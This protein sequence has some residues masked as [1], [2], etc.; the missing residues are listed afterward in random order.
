MSSLSQTLGPTGLILL[1]LQ[2]KYDNLIY[3]HTL[4]SGYSVVKESVQH[5]SSR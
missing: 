4:T 1:L 5:Q 3:F 2:T